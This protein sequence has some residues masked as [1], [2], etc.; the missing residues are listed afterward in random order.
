MRGSLEI[1]EYKNFLLELIFYKTISQRF[2][3][4]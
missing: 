4:W 3:E 1:T 2:E